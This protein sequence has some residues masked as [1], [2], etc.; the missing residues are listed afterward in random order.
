MYSKILRHIKSLKDFYPLEA[1]F[2]FYF[3]RVKILNAYL[4]ALIEM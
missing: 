2:V 3:L 4:H 1:G